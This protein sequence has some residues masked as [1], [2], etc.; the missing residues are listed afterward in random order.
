MATTPTRP[1]SSP[2]AASGKSVW[3]SG[4]GRR[5]P[6]SGRPSPRPDARA[7]RRGRT[8]G[9]TG[10]PG[11]PRRADRRTGRSRCR[12][13]PDVVEQ[14]GHAA[15]CRA[16]N[17]TEA[18]DDEADP[19]G[20]GIGQ[21]QEHGEEQQRRAEVALDDDDAEGDGPHR[22]H[23]REVRQRRQAQRPD[24]RVLLDEQR[25][26]LGQVAGQEDDEDDLQQL[27]RL[28]A[29]RADAQGQPL[30][31]D[32]RAEHEGQQQQGDADGRPR[33]LVAAQPAVRADDDRRAS[34][35]PRWPGTARAA[36]P[37]RGRASWPRTSRV[38]R[39]CGSRCMSSS[40]MPPSIPTAG[41]RTWSDR[42]PARTWA[43]CARATAPR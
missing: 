32:L 10:R 26:V 2:S 36:G 14:L 18:D 15:R 35:R 4:I 6:T 37:R 28:A 34:W 30:A 24:P 8:R 13:G 21:G 12:S 23:R 16:R 27:R 41:S 20:R 19:T 38:W 3:I 17:R 43:M 31:A 22:D 1:S 42:R 29:E 9:A 33:V 11:S 40:E 5:P 39:S 25:P 7:G